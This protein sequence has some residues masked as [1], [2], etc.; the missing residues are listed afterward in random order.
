M[1][2]AVGYE[3]GRWVGY[4]VP[5]ACDMPECE[6]EIDRG[7]GYKCEEWVDY[8]YQR[9]GELIEAPKFLDDETEELEV[10]KDGCGLFFCPDHQHHPDHEQAT[11]KLDSEEWQRHQ[12][13]DETW[14]PWRAE[15]PQTVQAIRERLGV[16][17]G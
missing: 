15:N 9:H 4:G 12:L 16:A 3:D 5:A 6:T 11:P 7:M 2:W 8:E 10:E 1:G 17:H 13:T 14:G